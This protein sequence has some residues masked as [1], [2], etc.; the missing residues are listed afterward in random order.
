MFQSN[1]FVI[2]ILVVSAIGIFSV[3]VILFIAGV[4]GRAALPT[5]TPVIQIPTRLTE[6]S[7]VA[8]LETPTE[9]LASPRPDEEGTPASS[10]TPVETDTPTPTLCPTPADWFPYTVQAGDTLF[11]IAQ[12]ADATLDQLATQ[13][14]LA[15]PNL[16]EV[17]QTIYVPNEILPT[18]TPTITPTVTLTPTLTPTVTPTAT[19]TVTTTLT[20]TAT[21][22]ASPT[23]TEVAG[24]Q[25]QGIGIASFGVEPSSP[26]AGESVTVSWNVT[27]EGEAFLNWLVDG[28]VQRLENVGIGSGSLE[29]D[30]P[31]VRQE[32]KF[33]LVLRDT[34]GRSA[35][36]ELFIETA[37]AIDYIV[38]ES[39]VGSAACPID[40]LVVASAS[41]QPF[42]NGFMLWHRVRNGSYSISAFLNDGTVIGSFPDNWDGEDINFGE[43][44]PSGLEQPTMGFGRVWVDESAVR[45]RL[46]WATAFET[47]YDATSQQLQGGDGDGDRIGDMFVTLPGGEVVRYEVAGEGRIWVEVN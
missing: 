42:E 32:V 8:Q 14:C 9:T 13:N 30:M 24:G 33:F 22:D 36:Q 27:G 3:G 1:R 44:P 5:P 12:A 46:G 47:G 10:P 17:G 28:R 19:Q 26:I 29:V 15:D 21:P 43:T 41:Y 40:E 37:C 45:D 20:P 16:L 6:E 39:R 23:A 34:A 11:R 7:A 38:D 4:R 25:P 2:P 31:L 18:A 35:Q